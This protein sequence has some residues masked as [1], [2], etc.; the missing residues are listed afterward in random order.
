MH[1][2]SLLCRE[3]WYPMFPE[4]VSAM[5]L[6]SDANILRFCVVYS[7]SSRCII[8]PR[9][10]TPVRKQ[11]KK[12]AYAVIPALK[13]KMNFKNVYIV[14]EGSFLLLAMTNFY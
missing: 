11:Q 6:S 8:A 5:F 13:T 12:V 2:L 4:F 1:T 14:Y 9:L 10:K 7:V 3:A